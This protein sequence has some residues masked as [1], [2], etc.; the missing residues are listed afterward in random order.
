MHFTGKARFVVLALILSLLVLPAYASAQQPTQFEVI[1]TNTGS[2]QVL[3]PAVFA[4]HSPDVSVFRPGQQASDGIRILAEDGAVEPL[5]PTL[6]STPGV[7]DVQTTNAPIP[8]GQSMTVRIAANPGD[9]LFVGSMLVQTNDGFAGANDLALTEGT[10]ALQTYDAGTEENNQLASHVPGPP[11]GGTQ[12]A[13]TTQ[14]IQAHPGLTETGDVRPAEWGFS[15]SVASVA[16][17]QVTDASSATTS[18]A[19][20]P[21]NE[22]SVAPIAVLVAASGAAVLAGLWLRRRARR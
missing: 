10:F 17:R 4:T 13:P 14:A 15:G 19:A 3:S 22:G 11:F 1:L 20:A 6:R 12:R 21:T 7:T 2:S 5:A 8:P 16:I 18:E 9:V